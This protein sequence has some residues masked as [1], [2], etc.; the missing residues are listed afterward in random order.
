[1]T[2]SIAAPQD[3]LLRKKPKALTAEFWRFVFTALVCIYHGEFYYG[4]PKLLPSGESAVEFFFIL[5]GFLLM[6]SVSRGLA[7]REDRPTPA[8][9]RGKALEYVKKKVLP[10]YP[11]LLIALILHYFVYPFTVSR[12][13]FGWGM[14]PTLLGQLKAFM[15]SEWEFLFLVNTPFGYNENTTPIVPMWFLTGLL[16]VGYIY[17]YLAYRHFDLMK[18]LAPLLGVL[19]L[20]YFTLNSTFILDFYLKMGPFTAGVV[21]AFTSM[22][23]GMTVFLIY[24]RVKDIKLHKGWIVLLSILELYAIYR[25]FALTIHQEISIDNFRRTIYIMII[26][27]M[28]F[29]N[30]TFFARLL[31]RRIWHY[32][33]KITLT[34]Y[35]THFGLVPVYLRLL[36]ITKSKL[37]IRAYFSPPAKKLLEFLSDMGNMDRSFRLKP[38]SVKDIIFYLLFVMAAATVIQ[39]FI[40]AVG[41]FVIRPVNG[42]FARRR[43]EKENTE[44]EAPV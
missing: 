42:Y 23:F 24:D 19:G 10:I 11:V 15:N 21:R 25:F 44:A 39:L 36:D 40:Y 17:T 26:L 37:G 4:D 30:V 7:R 6:L 5:S 43:A 22:A 28:A 38:M 13:G 1:M 8:E 33:G 27:L 20:T 32:L 34:M 3:T 2:V 29:L 31:N 9:A 16:I 35:L 12:F 18:F 41:R 14:K